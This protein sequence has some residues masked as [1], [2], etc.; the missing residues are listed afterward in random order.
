MDNVLVAPAN[1]TIDLLKCLRA[2]RW[3]KSVFV[4]IGAGTLDTVEPYLAALAFMLASSAVYIFNDCIDYF[5]DQHHPVKK[6]RPIA[7]DKVSV[8]AALALAL[9][10]FA[11]AML[12]GLYFSTNLCTILGM[13]V[14][15]NSAY[16]LYLKDVPVV[17]LICVSSGTV[18]R[19]LAGG[20]P[21]SMELMLF[22]GAFGT[23]LSF[24]KRRYE[25]Y[26]TK[27]PNP[28]YRDVLGK[29]SAYVLD[30]GIAASLMC[31]IW[32]I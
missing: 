6:Q 11:F 32:L 22:A 28:L 20:E 15:I 10:L 3:Y 23:L 18:L 8:P 4:L 24:G 29:Y 17:E 5:Y 31:L 7:S 2:R 30:A 9:P 19:V 13:Y 14:L 16:T 27:T 12:L 1:K 25:L 26:K 21:L